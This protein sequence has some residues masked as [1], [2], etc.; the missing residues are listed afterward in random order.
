VKDDNQGVAPGQRYRVAG[1]SFSVWEVV[2]IA[3][4]PTEPLPH[5]RLVRVGAAHDVKTVS[6]KVLRDKRYYQPVR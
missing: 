4:Y 2:A 6:L 5:V 1:S 3:R